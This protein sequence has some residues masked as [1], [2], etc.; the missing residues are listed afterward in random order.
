MLCSLE[1]HAAG[2]AVAKPFHKVCLFCVNNPVLKRILV[3]KDISQ[4]AL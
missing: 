3:S 1:E 2:P 4:S